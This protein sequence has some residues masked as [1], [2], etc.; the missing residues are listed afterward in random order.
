MQ[1]AA[2]LVKLFKHRVVQ[3]FF[4]AV[5]GQGCA[6]AEKQIGFFV[7]LCS[8]QEAHLFVIVGMILLPALQF[9]VFLQVLKHLNLASCFYVEIRCLHFF[10][11]FLHLGR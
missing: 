5:I 10:K 9:I 2:K 4:A 1:R 8:V 3:R 7:I 6:V 11:G